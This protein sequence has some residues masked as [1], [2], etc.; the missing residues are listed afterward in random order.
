MKRAAFIAFAGIGLLAVTGCDRNAFKETR[1]SEP[2]SENLQS[3]NG[4]DPDARVDMHAPRSPTESPGVKG[5]SE[6]GR[7]H[8][9]AGALGTNSGPR[10]NPNQ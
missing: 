9:P 4:V 1:Y 10:S 6:G 3:T 7:I 2:L 5:S 8:D